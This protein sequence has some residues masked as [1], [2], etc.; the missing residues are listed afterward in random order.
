MNKPACAYLYAFVDG[1]SNVNSL[2]RLFYTREIDTCVF[3]VSNRDYGPV[4]VVIVWPLR[5]SCLRLFELQKMRKAE[6][7]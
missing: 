7:M 3:S 2:C 5:M 4:V 1:P 6:R